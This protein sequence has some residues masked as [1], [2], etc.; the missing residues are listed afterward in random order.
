MSDTITIQR[1][2]AYQMNPKDITVNPDDNPRKDYGTDDFEAL[3]ESIKEN[4]LQYPVSVHEV[5][6]GGKTTEVILTH[7]FRRMKAIQSLLDEGVDIPTIPVA[8]SNGDRV[9]VLVDHM[10]LNG[11]KE[12]T[13][14]EKVSVVLELREN[15]LTYE[16]IGQ[17]TGLGTQMAYNYGQFGTKASKN[18]KEAVQTGKVTFTTASGIIRASDSPEAQDEALAKGEQAAANQGRSTVRNSDVPSVKAS[19]SRKQFIELVTS[20]ETAEAAIDAILETCNWS[21][22]EEA[23]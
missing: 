3:K 21:L 6:D 8:K 2:N 13:V 16:E 15:G 17:R 4:G 11:G 23:E 5:R 14:V 10:V 7:G 1:K 20:Y 18:L 12:L 19:I 9:S 22:P